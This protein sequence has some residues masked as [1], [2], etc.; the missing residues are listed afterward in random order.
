MSLHLLTEVIIASSDADRFHWHFTAGESTD[1]S[2]SSMASATY[3]RVAKYGDSEYTAANI[4]LQ[5]LEKTYTHT[6]NKPL[7]TVTMS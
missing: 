6:H 2:I 5:F 1:R 3:S 4:V 7:K